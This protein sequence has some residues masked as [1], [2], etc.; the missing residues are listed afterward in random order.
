MKPR[1]VKYRS[2]MTT[3]KTQELSVEL[4]LEDD[5][6][7]LLQENDLKIWE[8]NDKVKGGMYSEFYL[9]KNDA[10]FRSIV[11]NGQNSKRESSLSH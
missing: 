10:L 1:Y 11:Y 3:L 8:L 6:F 7:I 9:V 4:P 2:H 5:N